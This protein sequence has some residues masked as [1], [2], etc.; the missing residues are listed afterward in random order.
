MNP[1]WPTARFGRFTGSDLRPQLFRLRSYIHFW[2]AAA[3]SRHYNNDLKSFMKSTH[4][5]AW[6]YAKGA[7]ITLVMVTGTAVLMAAFALV[8]T[9]PTEF[10]R[11]LLEPPVQGQAPT[12][13]S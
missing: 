10:S 2:L 1:G 11:D 3:Y 7:A 5:A 6:A 4:H 9:Q 13:S 12:P 8:S